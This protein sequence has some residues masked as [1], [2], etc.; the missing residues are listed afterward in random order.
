MKRMWLA[1]LAVMILSVCGWCA[2]N[3]PVHWEPTAAFG[4][5][6][7]SRHLVRFTTTTT[8]ANTT[9]C[10]VSTHT[11][12]SL[13]VPSDVTFSPVQTS[14]TTNTW[15]GRSYLNF[16]VVDT[17]AATDHVSFDFRTVDISTNTSPW[18]LEGQWLSPDD[19]VAWQGEVCFKAPSTFT[20]TGW[21]WMGRPR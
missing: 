2:E 3:R 9:V 5:E 6:S 17:P 21:Y 1:G 20:V 8:A 13:T 15:G 16:Q 12:Y 11:A 19:P 7:D 18:L 4:W 10:V 14:S